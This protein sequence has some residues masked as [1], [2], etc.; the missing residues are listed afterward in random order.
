MKSLSPGKLGEK[1][2]LVVGIGLPPGRNPFLGYAS[3]T[4]DMELGGAGRGASSSRP[5]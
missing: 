4:N 1:E 5:V 3:D 2:K